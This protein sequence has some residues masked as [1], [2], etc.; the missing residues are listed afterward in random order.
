MDDVM[1][2]NL[3]SLQSFANLEP[4]LMQQIDFLGRQMRSVR[5]EIENLF[6]I[7]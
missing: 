6:L 3:S 4:H 1:V 7:G 2:M 5:P